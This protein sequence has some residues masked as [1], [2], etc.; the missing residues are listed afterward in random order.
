MGLELIVGISII[1][2]VALGRLW[3]WVFALPKT[4]KEFIVIKRESFGDVWI[5]PKGEKYHTSES[6]VGLR[7]AHSATKR[8]ICLHCIQ[9]SELKGRDPR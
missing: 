2:G 7:K 5:S 8:S 6:C 3:D 9:R 4:N 1:I